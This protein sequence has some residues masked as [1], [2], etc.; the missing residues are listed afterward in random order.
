MDHEE[1]HG[2]ERHSQPNENGKEIGDEKLPRT[3][4]PTQN[5]KE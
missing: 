3:N 1:S 2:A 4:E 5:A